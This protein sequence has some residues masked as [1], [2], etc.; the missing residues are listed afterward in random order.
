[1]KKNK[2]LILSALAMSMVITTSAQ[3]H[4]DMFGMKSRENVFVQVDGVKK[5]P[6]KEAPTLQELL[7]CPEG[8]VFGGEYS[9][10]KGVWTGT[11]TADESRN[12]ISTRFYQYF[13]DCYYK[14]NGVRFLGVFNYFNLENYAWTYCQD[15]EEIN[16]DGEMIKPIKVKVAFYKDN[17]EDVFNDDYGQDLYFNEYGKY[18]YPGVLVYS[19]DLSSG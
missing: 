2:V 6:A 13:T 18:S 19:K 5:A 7:A 9:G 17:G 10:E 3:I 1:M 16:E 14:F 11:S 15:R 4:K 12:D 8:T